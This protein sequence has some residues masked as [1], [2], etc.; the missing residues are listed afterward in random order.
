MEFLAT[1]GIEYIVVIVYLLMLLPL[2]WW[3]A[4]SMRATAGQGVSTPARGWFDVPP[5]LHYHRGH[6]WAKPE[7]DHTFRVGVDDFT[8]R[9][10]GEPSELKLPR[11]G[12][13]LEQGEHGLGLRVD[14]ELIG[15]RSPIG[16]EVVEVNEA[17]LSDPKLVGSDPY[18]NGWLLRVRS[19]SEAGALSNL[20]SG[21]LAHSWMTQAE[22]KLSELVG[23]EFGTVLQDGG[24]PVIGFVRELG[25]E[26]W[27]DLAAE[28]LLSAPTEPE[29]RDPDCWP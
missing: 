18:G 6:T 25:G 8:R 20:L 1:K 3:L 19:R 9:L 7:P 12:E 14:G 15:L 16:G 4:R 13:T 28:L 22:D 21:R 27:P 17:A 11:I 26:N 29:H 23:A 24:L 10:L 2:G 5:D